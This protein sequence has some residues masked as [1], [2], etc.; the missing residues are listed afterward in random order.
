[1]LC[2]AEFTPARCFDLHVVSPFDVSSKTRFSLPFL[3]KQYAVPV[4]PC[5]TSSASY[6]TCG[7]PSSIL[8]FPRLSIGEPSRTDAFK[9]GYDRPVQDKGRNRAA[10]G[11]PFAVMSGCA[12]SSV[13][14][15]VLASHHNLVQ[16]H[17]NWSEAFSHPTNLLGPS[18]F[19]PTSN[20]NTRSAVH[21]WEVIRRVPAPLDVQCR[22]VLTPVACRASASWPVAVLTASAASSPQLNPP[23]RL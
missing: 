20:A 10:C 18:S 12:Q 2:R 9:D 14:P 3:T 13:A 1:M 21:R 11:K 22:Q 6:P 19:V 4:K 16:R 7:A 15:D 5:R 17:C 23:C 8:V